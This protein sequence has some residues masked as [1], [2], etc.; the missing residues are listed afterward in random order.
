MFTTPWKSLESWV[1]LLGQELSN[2]TMK[3]IKTYTAILINHKQ[4]NLDTIIG[5]KQSA[6]IKNRKYYTHVPPFQM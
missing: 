5:E 2:K 4:K 1:L 6:A 3:T